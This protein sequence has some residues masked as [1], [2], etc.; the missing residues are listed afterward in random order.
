MNAE[1]I[2]PEHML[3]VVNGRGIKGEDLGCADWVT[4]Q[5]PQFTLQ[6]Y[7]RRNLNVIVRM[8]ATAT[9]YSHYYGTLRLHVTYPDGSPGGMKT[10]LVCLKNG[11]A[12]DDE[13][14][15]SD[16]RSPWPARRRRATS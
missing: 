15:R 6:R 14:D 3:N 13:S 4:V 2:L 10:A 8:P 11:K 5:P 16:V 12:T 1:F 9:Q 7:G